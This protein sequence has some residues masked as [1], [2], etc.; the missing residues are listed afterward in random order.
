MVLEVKDVSILYQTDYYKRMRTEERLA[1][2]LKNK[3]NKHKFTA[4]DHV[5]FVL[6][7]GDS[8]GII[9]RNG[10]GKSTL[11]RSIAGTIEPTEGQ[12]IR[13][14]PISALLELGTGFDG[15]LSV[16]ENIYLRAALL[17]FSK[18]SLEEK[19]D[20][21]IKFAELEEFEN[22]PYRTLSSGMKSHVG[23]AIV[24]MM[25]PEVL[26]LD[27]VFAAGDGA[28]RK[29]SYALMKKL[30]DSGCAAILV[31]HSLS[32]IKANCNRV[33]WLNN[34]KV[35]M[36]GNTKEVCQLYEAFL[37]TGKLPGEI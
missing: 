28:F 19:Y 16:K 34:G 26:I 8:L 21:I 30:I 6:N 10:A 13:Y 17:G 24:S 14:K 37:K 12:I 11:L 20:D 1:L 36:D 29:K 18:E 35:V 33:L 22:H 9:G 3:T 32:Q 2:K 4:V 23:F 25:E 27:E 7:E 5:S 15:D 31:S